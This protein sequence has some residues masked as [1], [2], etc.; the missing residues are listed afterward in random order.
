MWLIT[1]WR[2][3]FSYVE[4]T[5]E[6]G[7]FERFLN[8]CARE[9]IKIHSP[10]IENGVLYGKMSVRDYRN[11]LPIVRRSHTPLKIKSKHGL[12]FA[13]K[14]HKNR[15]GMLVGTAVFFVLIFA[16]SGRVWNV[17]ILGDPKLPRTEIMSL[18]NSSG[19]FE[20]CSKSDL[21][22]DDSKRIRDILLNN[23]DSLSWASI[24]LDG[25]FADVECRMKADVPKAQD[26]TI[27]NIIAQKGGRILEVK[28]YR[29][30]PCVKIGDAVQSGQ[31]LVSGAIDM[32][33]GGTLF[34]A[35]NAEI[36]AEVDE[37]LSTF[38]PF[39]QVSSLP[40]N[41]GIKRTVLT[42]FGFNLPLFFG[43]ID[44]D[45]KVEKNVLIPEFDGIRLPFKSTTAI[46]YPLQ[47]VSRTIDE[48]SARK[49][50]VEQLTKLQ[51]SQFG[52]NVINCSEPEF[53]TTEKGVRAVCKYT[54]KENIAKSE[55]IL[56]NP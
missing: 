15:S 42:A 1:L 47:K 19:V 48:N 34:C 50:A 6:K 43:S 23:I 49:L 41:T 30:T 27:C 31:L 8:L 2:Y 26:Y 40:S 28:A 12:R 18:L 29:G 53:L 20:G 35:A 21:L 32:T 56:I 11:I 54:C 16:L 37:Q 22:S 38:V 51:K 10:K 17:N 44:Y 5:A 45:C 14:K 7:F 3:I 9:N 33:N 25:C 46:F 4:F 36:Y 13:V 39:E 52:D 24:N 55:K